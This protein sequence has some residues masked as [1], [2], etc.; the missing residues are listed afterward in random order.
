MG[1]ATS[2]AALD[3]GSEITHGLALTGLITG[4][5]LATIDGGLSYPTCDGLSANGAVA[6]LRYVSGRELTGATDREQELMASTLARVH[7]VQTDSRAQPFMADL[8]ELVH[9]VEPWIRPSVTQVLA[10][11]AA[12]PSLIWGILHTD[13]SPEAF[14]MSN[15]LARSG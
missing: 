3:R 6:L 12:L 1:A 5:P 11:H 2:A 7:A 13:P 14:L 15:R 8:L 9:D 10:E 4:D